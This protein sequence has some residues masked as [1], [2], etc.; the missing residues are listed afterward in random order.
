MATHDKRK[1]NVMSRVFI[2]VSLFFFSLAYHAGSRLTSIP[3]VLAP[4][5]MSSRATL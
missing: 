4:A 3:S 1:Q 2:S 5:L